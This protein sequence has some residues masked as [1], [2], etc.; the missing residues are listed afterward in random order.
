[1]RILL[2]SNMYP[3]DSRPDYGVFVA[4]MA[5]ALRAAGHEVDEAVIRDDR[6]GRLR[7]PFKYLRLLATARSLARRNPDVVY[8]HYLVPTG[9]AAALTGVPFVITAHGRDVENA[10][11]NLVLRWATRWVIRRA[12]AVICVSEY[13][14]LRLPGAPERLAV[15]DSGVDTHRFAAA[16]GHSDGGPRFLFVGS[17]TERKNVRRL[18]DAFVRL[19]QGTLVI[20]GSGPLEDELRARA[21]VG[22]RFTGRLNQDQVASALRDA[23]IL[24]LPSLVEPFG[25]AAMEALASGRP[26][27]AT[28]EGGPAEYLTEACGVLVDPLDVESIANGLRRAMSL[29]VPC[30]AALTVAREHDVDRQAARVEEVLRAVSSRHDG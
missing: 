13:L 18:I 23:D 16:P 4:R 28:R 25:Q 8:A 6:S 11:R 17:L 21:P 1:V 15:I 2:L 14:A 10:R 27:V 5:E 29:P 24:C 7:T 19:G 20:A 12:A 26:V 9:L 22:V 30:P 3:S